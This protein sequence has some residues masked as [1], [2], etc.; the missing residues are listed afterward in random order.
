MIKAV[1]RS[2]IEGMFLNMIKAIYDN[3]SASIILNEEQ[4]KSFP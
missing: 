4:L 1:K 3:T 2:G